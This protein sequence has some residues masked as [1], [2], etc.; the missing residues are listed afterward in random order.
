MKRTTTTDKDTI[1]SIIHQALVCRVAMSDGDL[2]YVVPVCF[3]YEDGVLYFHSSLAGTKVDILRRN[4]AVCVEFDVD[5]EVIR[6]ESGCQ[7]GTKYRSVI[8]FGRASF[9]DDPAEKERALDVI[10]AHYEGEASGYA[11]ALLT[12]TAVLRV[13]I[14]TMTA[15]VSGY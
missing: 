3:G 11:E 15:K 6:A 5:Q 9:I 10:L 12:K 7:W 4:D 13:D 2:P 14:Q 1:E 8:G